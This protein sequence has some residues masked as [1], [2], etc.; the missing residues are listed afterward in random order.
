MEKMVLINVNGTQDK[1]PVR[2][3]KKV[4]D[5]CGCNITGRKSEMDNLVHFGVQVMPKIIKKWCKG[6]FI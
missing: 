4:G 1:K 5:I 2:K 6:E 3:I